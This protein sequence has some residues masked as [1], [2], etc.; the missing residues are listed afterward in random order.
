[1]HSSYKAEG[2]ILKRINFGEADK[3]LTVLARRYGKIKIL[4]KGVRK[5]TSRRA[6]HLELFNL[7]RLTLHKGQSFDIVTEAEY[8]S[9]F[10]HTKKDLHKLAVVYYISEL[11]DKLCPEHQEHDDILDAFLKILNIMNVNDQS[12]DHKL[13]A[14]NFTN[15]ILH[16]LGFLPKTSYLK[17]ENLAS[18][19]ESV[20]ESKIK[21]RELLNKIGYNLS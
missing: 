10:I 1:M 17:D 9:S 16:K 13:T 6:P 19:L 20:T 5:L 7:S 18:F 14:E 3:I 11:I 12:L 2:I 15:H 21:T 4:G 8:I